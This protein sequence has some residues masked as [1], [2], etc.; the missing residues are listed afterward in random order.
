MSYRQAD[1]DNHADK[2]KTSHL[3]DAKKCP[4]CSKSTTH[5]YRP[6]CS[7]RCADVD[8]SRWLNGNYAIPGQI[9]AEEAGTLPTQ[10]QNI[11]RNSKE[12]D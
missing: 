1:N 3:A 8:L 11:D 10:E 6:F 4:I 5:Q 7:K 2:Q 12:N 9:D